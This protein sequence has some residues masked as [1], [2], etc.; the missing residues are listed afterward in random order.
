MPDKRP[1]A[2]FRYGDSICW[3]WQ[4]SHVEVTGKIVSSTE[5]HVVAQDDRGHEHKVPHGVFY[6]P[7]EQPDLDE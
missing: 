4:G 6:K 5:R 3:R 1:P 7:G 2:R